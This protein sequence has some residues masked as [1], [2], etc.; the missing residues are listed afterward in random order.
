[1]TTRDK[2]LQLFE[3]RPDWRLADLKARTG[4]S[5]QII[6]RS[7][8]LRTRTSGQNRKSAKNHLPEN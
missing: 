4:L 7:R 1:M 8:S 5:T 2:L 6:H 3:D